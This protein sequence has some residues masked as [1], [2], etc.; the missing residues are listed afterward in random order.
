MA[1]EEKIRQFFANKPGKPLRAKIGG[2]LAF[3][4]LPSSIQEAIKVR[5]AEKDPIMKIG[6]EG[7]LPG[8]LIN[9]KEVTKDNIKDFEVKEKV[10]EVV[11]EKKVEDKKVEKP[12]EPD[13]LV[14][15]IPE[16]VEDIESM[17]KSELEVYAKKKFSIDIDKRLSLKKL[18]QKVKSLR[19]D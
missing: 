15:P 10:K 5:L 14:I 7:R 18:I 2:G 1:T 12:A 19:G 3:K 8:L 11:I 13:V 17:S 6:M 4:S 9:G 16:E